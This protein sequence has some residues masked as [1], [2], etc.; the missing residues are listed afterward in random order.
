MLQKICI[1]QCK[2]PADTAARKQLELLGEKVSLEILGKICTQKIRYSLS[3]FIRCLAKDYATAPTQ[4][5]IYHSPHKRSSDDCYSPVNSPSNKRKP[6]MAELFSE[7]RLPQSVESMLQKICIEQCKSPAD[8]SARKQLELLGEKVSLEIL[9]KI[10]TQKIRYSL[11]GFI[12]LALFV[13][14]ENEFDVVPAQNFLSTVWANMESIMTETRMM[15]A[16]REE[17][18]S[19]ERRAEEERA[20]HNAAKMPAMEGEV[21]LEH[22]ALESSTALA[23]IQRTADERTAKVAELEQKVECASLN[24]ELQ[25]MEARACCGQKKSPEDAN[26]MIQMQAWQEEAERA[27]QGQRD[28]ESKLSSLEAEVQKMRVEMSAMKRDA[29]H[30]SRQCFTELRC[31]CFCL[32]P[33]PHPTPPVHQPESDSAVIFLSASQ[34][35]V[36]SVAK[37]S[38]RRAE[39]ERAAHNAAKMPAM[40]GEVELEHQ[41]L[42]SSTALARIQRTADERTAKVAELEL[43]VEC[44]SLNQ[45]LQDMEARACCGQKKSPE[46]ANQMIQMQAWQEE[47]ERARQGQRDV[48]SK[49]SSLEAEV[50]KIRVE[51]SAMKRDAEHYSRQEHMELEKRY[52]EL[53]DLL[54][55]KQTQLEAMASEKAA[56][57][58]Q[59]EKE[60]KRLQEAQ[61]EAE[62]SRVSRRAS[63][64]WEEDT[65][66][67]TLE[68]LPLY[69][70]H[71]VGVSIQL[72]N[73]A[74]LLDSGAV[75]ATRF[76]WRY[77]IARILL[78]FYL[79]FVHFFLM[80]LLHRLQEQ[81]DSFSSRE[82]AESMGLANHTLQ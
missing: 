55:Y 82:V 27:R 18:A 51:M 78:L 64:S 36:I 53:T 38:E 12:S 6:T 26:Q 15:Q 69:H 24:Q 65:D 79:V 11:S 37:D 13:F 43:K 49:L 39:E 48:E 46:D 52:R 50:Q 59:L 77:P 33:T 54:Y 17:L 72:Q 63:S 42:E 1:E 35:T 40:E 67:K 75:R 22:Q 31:N 3:G 44:A 57:E 47:A 28:A 2:S 45:E 8:T 61:V 30:Y 9:G 60:M 74:K 80:Y 56:A 25:D 16:V 73:A 21:E 7:V 10:C 5:G 19:V 81:A 66:M 70:R 29:E 32:C 62:R 4:Q 41:A 76:L 20:A 14:S 68:P 58:F 71:M 23:R 34:S